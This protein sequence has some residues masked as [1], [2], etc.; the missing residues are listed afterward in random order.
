MIMR[1][2]PSQA[3]IYPAIARAVTVVSRPGWLRSGSFITTDR[4]FTS[5]SKVRFPANTYISQLMNLIVSDEYAYLQI[6]ILSRW[7]LF[8]GFLSA[9]EHKGVLAPPKSALCC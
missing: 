3:F 6:V 9:C 4:C 2:C 1:F 7:L 5:S 8:Q